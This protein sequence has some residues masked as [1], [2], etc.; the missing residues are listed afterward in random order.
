MPRF[1][2]FVLVFLA[3]FFVFPFS[4][5]FSQPAPKREF[6]A[7][8]IAT[9]SNIDW[10]EKRT[11]TSQEQHASFVRLL[12]RMKRMG[13]N[14]VI[15][16]IR[17]A[18]DAFYASELEPWSC[19]LTG[20]QGVAPNPFYDPLEFM[21]AE[22]H[23]RNMEFHAWFNPF[24]ALVDSKKNPNPP[25]H[26][27]RTHPDWLR[28]YGGK[29]YLDPGIPEAREYVNSVIMDVVRRYDIDA[30]HLDD[31]FYPYRVAGQVFPDAVSY[32]KYN[33]E[34]IADREDWRRRNVDLFMSALY[35]SIKHA[36]TYVKLGVSPFGVWR[37]QSKD[38]EGSPTR[39]GQ[40]NYD[41][42][43]A[44]VR[45]WM[46][47]G[48]VDYLLPQLYWEHGHTLV[49]F[50]TLL[51]WWR[52]HSYGRAM[53]F[54]L[55]LYRML[56]TPTGAWR[57][58]RELIAQ[59]RDTR[60]DAPGTGYSLYSLSNLNKII[61]PIEDSL[62]KLGSTIALVPQMKWIDSVAPLPPSVTAQNTGRGKLL[63]WNAKP[64]E[65]AWRY[66]VYRFEKGEQANLSQAS[67]ILAITDE[68]E[69]LDADPRKAYVYVV[70]AVDRLWNESVASNK[71]E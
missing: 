48:W 11:L 33:P 23:K 18:A 29:G 13:C 39:G 12:D 56:G 60:I 4:N 7:A 3:V 69:Y 68:K 59:I 9:V 28:I 34:H 14:A 20:K 6:R 41:D 62:E 26:V 51:P 70:T 27:T 54:G 8:W 31:Y 30:V 24:R 17:P 65:P 50:E 45:L 43:Y 58:T 57:G 25:G 66:V 67:N 5:A 64:G 61:A 37:N 63:K 10:P 16:Q 15:V 21:I 52:D 2:L 36:K 46:E 40:T 35:D 44:D 32:A 38:P 42:L 22:A 55:G 53:Y 47:K 19:Y 71:V 1:R 49:A